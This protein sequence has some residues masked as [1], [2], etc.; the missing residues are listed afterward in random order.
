MSGKPFSDVHDILLVNRL[1]VILCVYKINCPSPV[2]ERGNVFVFSDKALNNLRRCLTNK[3]YPSLYPAPE[4][5]C[6]VYAKRD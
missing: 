5:W 1:Y 6:W 3:I 4:P 2:K